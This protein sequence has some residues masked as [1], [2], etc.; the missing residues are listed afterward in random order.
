MS[1]AAGTVEFKGYIASVIRPVFAS[2]TDDGELAVFLNRQLD[3][4]EIEAELPNGIPYAHRVVH[5]LNILLSGL[6][7]RI[8]CKI[9]AAEAVLV[10][11]AA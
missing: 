1:K 11:W 7:E 10:G 5:L 8:K 6:R 4:W 2:S 3:E 9:A